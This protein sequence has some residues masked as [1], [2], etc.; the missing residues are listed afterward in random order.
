MTLTKHIK[1]AFIIGQLCVE[2]I[3]VP[4]YLLHRP[5]VVFEIHNNNSLITLMRYERS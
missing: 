3:S 5:S 4:D 1:Y 2:T